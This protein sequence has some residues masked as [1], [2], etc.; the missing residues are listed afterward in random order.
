MESDLRFE[1]KFLIEDISEAEIIGVIK[2]HPAC[3][4]EIYHEREVFNIY[5]DSPDFY[6]YHE[7]VAGVAERRKLRLRWYM[8]S[9]DFK[10]VFQFEIKRKFGLLGDKLNCPIGGEQMP[11]NALPDAQLLFKR[12]LMAYP[13]LTS[14]ES[15]SP[16]LV[17]SYRRR[18][19]RSAEGDFRIT[20]DSQIG[21]RRTHSDGTSF[22]MPNLKLH[23]C[24]VE[25]KYGMESEPKSDQITQ[26]IPFRVTR[27]SKYVMAVDALYGGFGL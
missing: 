8:G 14:F 9:P 21:A 7:N 10:G 11:T 3:F 15:Y 22:S 13:N 23:G 27:S 2:T 25:L 16:V 6:S 4:R 19:F 18:Y 26:N 17:N 5:F 24:V 12:A 20:V 1:R